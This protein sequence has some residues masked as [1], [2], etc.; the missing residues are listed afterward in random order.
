MTPLHVAAQHGSLDA[1]RTLLELG[2]DASLRSDN[3]HTPYAHNYARLYHG[4]SEVANVISHAYWERWMQQCGHHHPGWVCSIKWG[5]ER[6]H[7]GL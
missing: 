3:K 6:R 1:V 2:A 5:F 7:H 4:G